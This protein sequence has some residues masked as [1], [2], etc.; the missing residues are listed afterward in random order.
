MFLKSSGRTSRLH[1][2]AR[3]S[4]LLSSIEHRSIAP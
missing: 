2:P 1:A 4:T 3:A